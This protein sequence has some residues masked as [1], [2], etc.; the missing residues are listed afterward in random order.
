MKEAG[1]NFALP[2]VSENG[3]Y[4]ISIELNTPGGH[5]SIP[6]D[7]TAIGIIGALAV[8]MEQTPFLHLYL[9]IT[10]LFSI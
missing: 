3:M 4:D 7:H 9:L 1:V 2:G 10:Q 6:P 8:H 5:S